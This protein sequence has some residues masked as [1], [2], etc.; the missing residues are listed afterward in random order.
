MKKEQLDRPAECV[1][2]CLHRPI[3]ELFSL[4]RCR[5]LSRSFVFVSLFCSLL[6]KAFFCPRSL[7]YFDLAVLNQTFLRASRCLTE[8]PCRRRVN[9]PAPELVVDSFRLYFGHG[10]KESSSFPDR[11][12]IEKGNAR[13]HLVRVHLQH[14]QN[15]RR[16][17]A[18]AL[19]SVAKS[20]L[21]QLDM[22]VRPVGV[23]NFGNS[24]PP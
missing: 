1:H 8:S 22:T 17:R 15:P 4:E 7:L 16:Y 13:A 20:A 21:T 5:S 24:S 14:F 12:R 11:F 10:L 2:V 19:S 3:V 9:R 23:L 6:T 18:H